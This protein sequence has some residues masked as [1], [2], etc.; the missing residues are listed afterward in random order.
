M[1]G[2]DGADDLRPAHLA[3]TAL[4]H[5][6][7]DGLEHHIARVEDVALVAVVEGQGAK[8]PLH[9]HLAQPHRAGLEGNVGDA[10]H[11]HAGGH[12]EPE[13]GIARNRQESLAHRAHVGRQL[14][15]QGIEKHIGAQLDRLHLA[16]LAGQA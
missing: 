14:G 7:A 12:L 4:L 5:P 9:D 11:R 2:G 1:V 13:A 10:V 15:L 3:A 6:A 8:G 16:G